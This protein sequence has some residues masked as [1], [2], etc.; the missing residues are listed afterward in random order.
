M[1]SVLELKSLENSA[2][3]NDYKK[4]RMKTIYDFYNKTNIGCQNLT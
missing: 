2:T 1:L 3:I 4:A